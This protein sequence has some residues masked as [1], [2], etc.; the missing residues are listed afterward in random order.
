M[1]RSGSSSFLRPGRSALTASRP[2]WPTT[3]ATKRILKSPLVTGQILPEKKREPDARTPFGLLLRVF[4][5]P[6]LAHHGDADLA[7]KAQ[8]GFDSLGDI[9]RH[10]LGSR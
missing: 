10:Q 1:T 2:G 8:L 3:S 9:S 5:G 6:R 4:H 7:W